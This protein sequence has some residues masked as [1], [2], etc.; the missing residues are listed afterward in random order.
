MKKVLIALFMILILG[1]GI[2]GF[3]QDSNENQIVDPSDQSTNTQF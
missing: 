1:F 3:V 2:L